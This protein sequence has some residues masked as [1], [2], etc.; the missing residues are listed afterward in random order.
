LHQHVADPWNW[1]RHISV[2]LEFVEPAVTGEMDGVH[3]HR[4]LGHRSSLR[5]DIGFSMIANVITAMPRIAIAVQDFDAAVTTF[6]EQFGMPVVDFSERTVPDLG[7][8]VGMC[9]PAGGSNLE[10][11]APADPSKPLSQTLQSFLD[12]RG[13]GLYALMLEAPSPN[14]E[15]AELKGRGVNVM[16]LMKGAGGRDVHPSSTSGV[17]I[18]VYP[19]NSAGDFPPM[20]SSAPGFSGISRVIVAT[21]D[22]EAAAT[23]YRTGLGLNVRHVS[24]DAERGVK[25]AVLDPPT[26]GVIE[27]VEVTDSSRP[28]ASDVS[29]FMVAKKQGMFA[30]VLQADD[31]DAATAHLAGVNTYGTRFIIEQRP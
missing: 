1:D 5:S 3:R 18:R 8:H 7:A 20:E 29:A 2:V 6:R 10:L 14:D 17:L 13:E 9:I 30:L 4:E 22:V 27:L 12:R 15:A 16:P 23:A 28:F 11:M 25:A 24:S 21:T 31:V 26:G 19:E